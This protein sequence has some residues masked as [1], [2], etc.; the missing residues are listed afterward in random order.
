MLMIKFL[1]EYILI[2]AKAVFSV[3]SDVNFEAVKVT[4]KLVIRLYL[5]D[6]Y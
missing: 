1:S 6:F 5:T 3:V 2:A 4:I